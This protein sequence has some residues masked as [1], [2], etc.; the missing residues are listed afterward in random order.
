[1][2]IASSKV[3][4]FMVYLMTLLVAKTFLMLDVRIMNE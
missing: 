3:V 4:T 2:Q 1:M